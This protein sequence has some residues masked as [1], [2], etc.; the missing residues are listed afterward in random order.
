MPTFPTVFG[1][2]HCMNGHHAVALL[3]DA[4]RK[5]IR[6]FDLERAYACMKKTMLEE[7]LIPWYR[8]P[9]TELDRFYWE[10]GYFP[11]LHSGEPETVKEVTPG[12]KRQAVAVT[13]A[14]AYDAWCLAQI[15]RELGHE[16]DAQFFLSRA[17][18]YRNLWKADTGFF[19]P[20]DRDGQWILPFDYKYAGG[21]GA[22]DYYDE[23]NAWT[24]LWEVYHD[25][26]GLIGHFGGRRAFIDK[27]DRMFSE[28]Y[29]RPRWEHYNVLPDST[30]NVGMYVMG[31]EPSFHIPYL[32]ALAGEPWKTQKRIRMLLEAWFRRDLMGIPGDED[33]GGMS[34]FVV[35]SMM[36]FYPV[37]PGVPAYAIGSPVFSKVV[38]RLENGKQFVLSAPK[39]SRANK[40]IQSATLNGKPWVEP[41]F[42]HDV[43]A[44]GGTVTLDMAN[45]PNKAWGSSPDLVAPWSRYA[46][47]P[48]SG[49]K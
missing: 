27:L 40:Y 24:Y 3:A 39:A 31:N 22:R 37:T 12:E 15:A 6:G 45:R 34:A 21:Q 23:N 2:A 49:A 43:L 14:A 19:H 41:W 35:F 26:P 30:G 7:S 18:D 48:G 44:N 13:L 8:G 9:A 4:W 42:S 16:Q 5:G 46:P 36:G 25:I 38:I 1:D 11:A 29:E 32:Y 47:V 10:K 28:G 17:L 33:G 20:K